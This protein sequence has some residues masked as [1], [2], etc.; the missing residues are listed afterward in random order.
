[1][2]DY[3][4]GASLATSVP[5]AAEAVAVEMTGLRLDH[6]AVFAGQPGIQFHVALAIS[7]WQDRPATLTA[8]FY[9]DDLVS[10]PLI[11][12]AAPGQYRDKQDAVLTSAPVLPCCAETTYDDLPLFIPYAG[13]GIAQPGTYPLKV[14]VDVVSDDQAWRYTLSWEFITYTLR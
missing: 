13:F 5:G 12:P 7:G 2:A 14:Q 6:G 8:R 10:A 3:T 9:T 4:A 1:M 11:N